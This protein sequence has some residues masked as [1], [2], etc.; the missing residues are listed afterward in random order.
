ML[1]S[2]F[3]L[4]SLYFVCVGVLCPLVSLSGCLTIVVWLN[5]SGTVALEH[6]NVLLLRVNACLVPYEFSCTIKLYTHVRACVLCTHVFVAKG[7]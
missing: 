3:L 6:A 4:W 7:R 5:M 2:W 1:E